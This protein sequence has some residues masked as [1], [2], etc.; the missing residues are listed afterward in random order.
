MWCLGD[1]K[2][3]G[4]EDE[5]APVQQDQHAERDPTDEQAE[6]SQHTEVILYP[7]FKIYNI[8]FYISNQREPLK[9][10]LP[11]LIWI[12]ITKIIWVDEKDKTIT[13]FHFSD[14]RL[15]VYM[16]V[17]SMPSRNISRWDFMCLE[18]IEVKLLYMTIYWGGTALCV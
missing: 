7:K 12:W 10:P 18:Y 17:S 8:L 2:G 11:S 9:L 6:A 3:D 4:V 15:F 14:M 5:Q 13:N 1:R 16:R